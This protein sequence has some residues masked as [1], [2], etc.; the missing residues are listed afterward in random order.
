MPA[1]SPTMTEG[2]IA[3]WKVKEGDKFSAGDVL[4][5]IETDKAQMDVE[6][7]EDGVL[8][9]IMQQDGAKSIPVGTR[10]G[11]FAEEGDD[12]ASLEMPP[13]PSSDAPTAAKR[14]HSSSQ[15]ESTSAQESPQE[16]SPPQTQ[17]PAPPP[18]TH[19]T[20][21]QKYPLSPSVTMLLHHKGLSLEE[22]NNIPATGPR[23]R[24]LKG[25]VLAHLG[26]IQK[27]TPSK[28]AVS[29]SKLE[30]LDLSNIQL[31][32]TKTPSPPPQ[33][34]TPAAIDEL[35]P[36]DTEIAL[37]VSLH[38]VYETQHRIRTT[39]GI[40]LPL[41]TFIARAADLANDALPTP[42]HPPSATDLFNAVLGLPAPRTSTGAYLPHVTPLGPAVPAAP[43][44]KPLDIIDVL[45]ARPTPRR[46]VPA[47]RRSTPAPAPADNV[48]SLSVK[49]GEE[50]RAR[51]FLQR[52]K[53]TLEL[54]PGA[55]VM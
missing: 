43:L 17:S 45:T 51:T 16:T 24:L 7:Q 10:I 6:A 29:L 13:E 19:S 37:P 9:K 15:Q 22:A 5:D 40:D 53:T 48:F 36:S 44:T 38:A 39:L 32:P 46:P 41:S 49:K 42:T 14:D 25:D 30:H 28:L 2:N 52:V 26:Q 1:L 34:S 35:S 21:P 31:A 18:P 8:A 27:D 11:V 47:L 4:L 23:G 12:L 20:E 54:E 50:R 3:S 55:L 33:D